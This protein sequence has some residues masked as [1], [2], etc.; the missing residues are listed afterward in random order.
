MFSPVIDRSSNRDAVFPTDSALQ[1]RAD[2]EFDVV[3][4]NQYDRGGR[5]A[6]NEASDLYAAD[7]VDWFTRFSAYEGQPGRR[8]G[9]R[10][11]SQSRS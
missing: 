10:A 7:L 6:A 5:F 8:G 1:H 9:W 11:H 4:W 2:R 3:H